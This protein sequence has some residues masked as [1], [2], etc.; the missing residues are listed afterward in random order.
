MKTD[1]Q[2]PHLSAWVKRSSQLLRLTRDEIV[3]STKMG[4]RKASD[5]WNGKD[6]RLSYYL[7]VLKLLLNRS[8]HPRYKLTRR[9]LLE[10]L[11]EALLKELQNL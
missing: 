9:Q 6:I 2:F 8:D 3:H 4:S 11:I 1:Y 5:V 7:K 10:G